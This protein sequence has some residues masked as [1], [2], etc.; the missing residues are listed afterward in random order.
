MHVYSLSMYSF[1]ESWKWLIYTRTQNV[2]R[3]KETDDSSPPKKK[4]KLNLQKH[5]YPAIPPSADDEL[6]CKTNLELLQGEWEKPKN[7]DPLKVKNLFIRTHTLRRA[8][9]LN[10][11][12][13]TTQS[14]LQKYP[15][16]KKSSYVSRMYM[17]V[18][19]DYLYT[20][21]G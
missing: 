21:A 1:Q 20:C 4:Q 10:D 14:I 12:N 8:E 17:V 6:S 9:V 16:L 2:N 15:M 19:Q 18:L 13:V 3:P 5:Q 7:G 11:E